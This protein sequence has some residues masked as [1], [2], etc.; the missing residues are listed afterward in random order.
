LLEDFLCSKDMVDSSSGLTALFSLLVKFPPLRS[1]SE[2]QRFGMLDFVSFHDA[3]A[4]RRCAEALSSQ[5]TSSIETTADGEGPTRDSGSARLGNSLVDGGPCLVQCPKKHTAVLHITR[6]SSFRCDLCGNG[7]ERGRIMHGCRECDWDACEECTDKAESGLVKCSAIRELANDCRKLLVAK[8][9]EQIKKPGESSANYMTVINSIGTQATGKDLEQLSVRLLR[10]DRKA[11]RD[12]ALML[13]SPGAITV[14]QFQNLILPALHVACVGRDDSKESGPR[15]QRKKARVAAQVDNE[16]VRKLRNP[17]ERTGFCIELVRAMI[18]DVDETPQKRV[19][20]R[21]TSSETNSGN[22]SED[23][24]GSGESES[25]QRQIVCEREIP[26]FA[27]AS[28]LLRRLQQVLSLYENVNVS[29]VTG[30]KRSAA[31]GDLQSLTKLIELHLYPSTF[32][33]TGSLFP[34]KL[35]LH[36]EPLVA[37]KDIKRHI[38]RCC[39]TIDPLYQA[40]CRR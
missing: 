36:S 27:E 20:I 15:H 13:R 40:F 14:H 31:E 18:L 4:S 19:G 2:I 11:I 1:C 3:L 28:E 6:H 35:V 10:Y 39:G 37:L 29:A 23:G 34:S 9:D 5:V 8:P 12:L 16:E 26:F 32:G 17:E 25:E 7:V 21:I 38:L 24:E 30:G 22:E 33:E